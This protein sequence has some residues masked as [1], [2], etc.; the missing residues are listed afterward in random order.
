V[1]GLRTTGTLAGLRAARDAGLLDASDTETLETAWQLAS[2]LRDSVVLWSGRSGG[3]TADVLPADRVALAGIARTL[4]YPPASG[5]DL[6]EDYLR[7]ARR[8][9]TVME[10]VFYGEDV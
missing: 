6:E 2:N 4:H 8:A 5:S 3:A 7:A 10:R 1:P 9:R